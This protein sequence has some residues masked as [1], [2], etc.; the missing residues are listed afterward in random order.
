MSVYFNIG[1]NPNP[2]YVPVDCEYINVRQLKQLISRKVGVSEADM[3][4]KNV[5][6]EVE[7]AP[8]EYIRKG[9]SVSVDISADNMTDEPI[10]FHEIISNE[11]L[12]AMMDDCRF[13]M[14]KSSNEDNVQRARDGSIWATTM[15]NQVATAPF[16][17]NLRQP[18]SVSS[19]YFYC[20][21]P[22]AL[23]N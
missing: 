12:E 18:T 2:D 9:A 13:Y 11:R 17:I 4:I 10:R 6:S 3:K 20:L 14:V 16:R 5:I 19:T 8:N 15:P 1:H 22:I 21:V 23:R 7:Y